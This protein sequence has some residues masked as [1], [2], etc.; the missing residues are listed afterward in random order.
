MSQFL[1]L[2]TLRLICLAQHSTII[3]FTL[4]FVVDFEEVPLQM[5]MEC[6]DLQCSKDWKS[7]FFA[8]V[9]LDY[10]N[11][12]MFLSGWFPKLISQQIVSMFS[13]TNCCEQFISKMKNPKSML[14]LQLSNHHLSEVVLQ[15]TSSFNP[16]ITF[17]LW[18][19]TTSDV[20]LI[21]YDSYLVN[22]AV[23]S[24]LLIISSLILTACQSI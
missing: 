2:C 8:C 16:D 17:F 5:Q 24:V 1:Y 4:T 13:T 18:L 15:S 6:I 10:Y 14:Y 22:L 3:I 11:N 12:R 21:N 23:F 7:E 9:I 20:S 19:Q